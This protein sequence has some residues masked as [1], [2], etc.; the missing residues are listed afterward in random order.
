MT[1]D[2]NKS[3]YVKQTKVDGITIIITMNQSMY[4]HSFPLNI[5][6][7]AN[8]KDISNI[9]IIIHL[10]ICHLIQPTILPLITV[11]CVTN[12]YHRYINHSHLPTIYRIICI[13]II[14]CYQIVLI[15][16]IP[17]DLMMY[18]IQN[19]Q[20]LSQYRLMLL[21]L[22]IIHVSLNRLKNWDQVHMA[23]CIQ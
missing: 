16:A 9:I 5:H 20:I 11:Q 8:T 19:R 6:I 23:Q 17:V 1:Q 3:H 10:R 12:H 15:H 13:V 14:S 21:I 22:D 2:P 18:R 4:P 7:I